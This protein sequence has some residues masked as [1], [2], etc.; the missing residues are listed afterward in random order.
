MTLQCSFGLQVG[1]KEGYNLEELLQAVTRKDI[2]A[3]CLGLKH[4][5]GCM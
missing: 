3:I 4:Q 1:G 2:V 5:V